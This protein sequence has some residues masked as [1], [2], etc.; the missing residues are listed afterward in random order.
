MLRAAC[1]FIFLIT[2]TLCHAA[3]DTA[4]VHKPAVLVVD[5]SQ[6]TP[7]HVDTAA[8]HAYKKLPE[9]NYQEEYSGPS[10]WTRFWRWFW[11]LF[12]FGTSRNRTIWTWFW[13]VIKYLFLGGA[14]AGLIFLVMKSAGLNL[15]SLFRR[16][17]YTSL[18]YSESEEN[19][20][21]IDF[22]GELEK[23]LAVHNYRFA[24]RLLYLRSLKQLSDNGLINW[25]INKTNTNYVN[26]L[27]QPDQREAFK[28][29]TRQFEYV[30]YGDFTI[31]NEIYHKISTLFQGFKGGGK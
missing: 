11:G 29:L 3:A 14:I 31:N 27:E 23:A 1:L 24:V 28:I 10:L 2:A 17:P 18:E 25:Q 20:H 16:K 22:E 12:D 21:E 13:I 26:E 9:F 8:L 4:K 15:L 19:I 30:W 7:R 6:V 5:S